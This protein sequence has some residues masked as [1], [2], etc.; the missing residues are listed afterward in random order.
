MTL[1]LLCPVLA[2]RAEDANLAILDACMAFSSLWSL[3]EGR[4]PP[5]ARSR[6]CCFWSSCVV[7]INSNILCMAPGEMGDGCGWDGGGGVGLDEFMDPAMD[8]I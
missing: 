3:S 8:M 4:Y 7:L 2:L 6:F 1:H 5:S